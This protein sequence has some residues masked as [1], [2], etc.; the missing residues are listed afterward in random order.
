MTEGATGGVAGKTMPE[1]RIDKQLYRLL[2]NPNL[3]EVLVVL[4]ER[5]A[6]PSEIAEILRKNLRKVIYSVEQLEEMSLIE[7]VDTERRRGQLAHVYRAVI[8][9]IW[10]SEEWAALSQDERE[11]YSS[12]A[13]QLF[14]RDVAIAWAGGTFQAR[15][16]SHTSRSPLRVDEQGWGDINRIQDEAL[17]AFHKVEVESAKRR[18][19]A[20]EDS[21]LILVR[22]AMFCIEMPASYRSF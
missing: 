19:D 1:I 16:D 3:L 22:A 11:S 7:L 17:A 12:W 2:R 9:P 14:L 8:R 10:K 20:G 4:I 18:G 13:L 6:S 21:E 5:R 15:V